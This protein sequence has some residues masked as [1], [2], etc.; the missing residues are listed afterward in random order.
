MTIL[1]LHTKWWHNRNQNAWHYWVDPWATVRIS[2]G[3]YL[4]ERPSP[5]HITLL[6]GWEI[7]PCGKEEGFTTNSIDIAKKT[8]DSLGLPLPEGSGYRVYWREPMYWI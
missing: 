8:L 5:S 3:R 7:D 1:Y 4:F 6:D 2:G